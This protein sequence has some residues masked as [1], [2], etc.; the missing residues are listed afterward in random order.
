M[1]ELIELE[2]QQTKMVQNFGE[3]LAHLKNLVRVGEEQMA[4]Q[5]ALTLGRLYVEALTKF[6]TTSGN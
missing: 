2:Q 4:N 6:P 1:N 3:G 5:V